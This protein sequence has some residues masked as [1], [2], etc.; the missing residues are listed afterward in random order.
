MSINST[1]GS[2]PKSSAP[3]AAA[4][5][6][7][8]SS[9]PASGG[10]Q[11]DTFNPTAP[12]PDV[13]EIRT[14]NSINNITTEGLGYFTYDNMPS[15]QYQETK[16]RTHKNSD[17]TTSQ[18]SYTT[19]NWSA[20]FADVTAKLQAISSVADTSNDP[21]CRQ[22][23]SLARQAINNDNWE[24][25]FDEG[26]AASRYAAMNATLQNIKTLTDNEPQEPQQ[27][28][29][30]LKSSTDNANK[31]IQDLRSTLKDPTLTA[32]NLEQKT[33][34]K[35]DDY[36]KKANNI[37]FWHYLLLFGFF[38]KGSDHGNANRLQKDLA[39]VKA[40]NP[41][42]LQQQLNG[43]VGQANKVDQQAPYANSVSGAQSLED[44]ARG[45]IN[46]ANN[47]QNSAQDQAN[48]GQDLS[49]SLNQP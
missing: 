41:D 7:P 35:I 22:I 16:Y 12:V 3:K 48:Q 33:Q 1:S 38:Q 18:E 23:G 19:Y 10:V 27:T 6:A 5:A 25:F 31:A 8:T 42:G 36:N 45:V 32:S 40:A 9:A 20:A 2:S 34:A 39:T 13:P 17:G 49:K 43:V 30:Q 24:Y 46:S 29:S 28:I 26:T 37:P 47:I 4:P 14:L 15:W 21:T 44:N 11:A